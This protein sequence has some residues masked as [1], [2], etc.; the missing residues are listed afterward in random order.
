MQCILTGNPAALA[1][2]TLAFSDSCVSSGTP[3]P[4]VSGLSVYG[5]SR[6]PVYVDVTPSRNPFTPVTLNV[7]ELN[8]SF[9]FTASVKSVFLMKAVKA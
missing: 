7:D 6:S 5:S 4:V 3:S 1:A 2:I 8:S 9:H